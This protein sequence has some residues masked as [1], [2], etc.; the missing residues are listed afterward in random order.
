MEE[1]DD[2]IV[3]LVK[4]LRNMAFG[5]EFET[6]MRFVVDDVAHCDRRSVL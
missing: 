4:T 3:D 2:A 5:F 1:S 6:I